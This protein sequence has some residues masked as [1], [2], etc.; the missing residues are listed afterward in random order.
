[1]GMRLLLNF[2]EEKLLELVLAPAQ[3]SILVEQKTRPR[4]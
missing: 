1:M 4:T 3:T 2:Y